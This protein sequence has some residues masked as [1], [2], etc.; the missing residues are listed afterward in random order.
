M[1]TPVSAGDAG[2]KVLLLASDS[3]MCF[4]DSS[5]LSQRKVDLEQSTS[6]GLDFSFRQLRT[7]LFVSTPGSDELSRRTM[8]SF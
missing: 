4:L 1:K 8:R 3:I 5:F 7:R 2:S 6:E